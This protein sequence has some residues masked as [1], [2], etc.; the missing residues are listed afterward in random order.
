MTEKQLFY[1]NIQIN[2]IVGRV[3]FGMFYNNYNLV[4]SSRLL[5][6]V[7]GLLP[8]PIVWLGMISMYTSL[9]ACSGLESHGTQSFW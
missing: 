3:S 7:G 9:P 6:G 8:D 4:S 1:G 2:K 5:R